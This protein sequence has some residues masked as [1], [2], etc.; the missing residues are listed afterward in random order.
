MTIRTFLA[1]E[2]PDELKK[3]L[4]QCQQHLKKDAPFP[5]WVRPEAM[6]LTV[7]FLGDINMAQIEP[8]RESVAKAIGQQVEFSLAVQGLGVFPSLR[9]PRI[10]WAGITEGGEQ[11]AALA[12]ALDEALEP[13]GFPGEDREYTPH[14][15]LA[16]VKDHSREVGQALVTHGHLAAPWIFGTLPVRQVGLFQSERKLSGSVYTKLW[17][18]PLVGHSVL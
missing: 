16:R 9:S 7:K 14:L 8:I 4:V 3:G 18:V 17:E 6:H 10:I 11:I 2:L 5:K 13:L 1:V 12:R 15:T